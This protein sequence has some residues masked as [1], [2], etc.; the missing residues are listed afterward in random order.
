MM[1]KFNIR[2]LVILFSLI[3]FI[4]GFFVLLNGDIMIKDVGVDEIQF[5]EN[6]YKESFDASG[7]NNTGKNDAQTNNKCPDLL[8]KRDGKLLLYNSNQPKQDGINPIEFKDLNEYSDYLEKQSKSG[9]VCPVLFLQKETDA[10]NNNMYRIRQSPFYVEG[11]LPALPIEVHDNSIPV[12]TTDATR[13]NGYNLGT[14]PGFDPYNMNIGRYSDLDVI[15][16][17]TEKRQGGSL[18]PADPNWLGVVSTQQAVDSGMF[19]ENELN[20]VIYPKIMPI[21]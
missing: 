2:F 21:Q 13:D 8:I 5:F 17:S 1:K 7:N 20:K 16:D 9:V 3:I 14:Y 18:N 12:E 10:Q 11:G 15:H 4:S 19:K 6:T